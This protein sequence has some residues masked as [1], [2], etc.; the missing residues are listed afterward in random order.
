MPCDNQLK[1]AKSW[2]ISSIFLPAS[3]L[4][5]LEKQNTNHVGFPA[6]TAPTYSFSFVSCLDRSF[7]N[8]F[9]LLCLPL[10]LIKRKWQQP[11]PGYNLLWIKTFYSLICY[12]SFITIHVTSIA[13]GNGLWCFDY[14]SYPPKVMVRPGP[15]WWR[16][17]VIGIVLVM[18]A[19]VSRMG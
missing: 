2:W 16:Q 5:Q 17:S 4:G 18:K 19:E 11:P 1:P 15:Q 14:G 10:A 6:L 7:P 9:S 3:N 12:S 8:A 13:E